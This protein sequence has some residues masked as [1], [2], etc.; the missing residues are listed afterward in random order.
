MWFATSVG[1]F[2]YDSK[3]FKRYV[4]ISGDKKS[5]ASDDLK[6]V[7]C[8][9][10]GD[11]WIGGSAGLDR[12]NRETDSFTHFDHNVPNTNPEHNNQIFSIFEDQEGR[13]L[14]A[15]E[16]GINAVS[17]NGEKV[18]AKIIMYRKFTGGAQSVAFVTQAANGEIW[19]GS[20]NGLMQITNDGEK[21][22]LYHINAKEKSP[23]LNEFS[24]LHIS[25]DS[26]WL[27][28]GAGGLYCFSIKTRQFELI[29]DFKDLNGSLPI[30]T[31][32]TS[33][34]KGNL[35]IS[36]R[37]GL[38]YFDPISRKTRWY[39]NR[40]GNPYSLAEN[41][42]LSMC[43]DKQGG[44]WLGST[45]LGVSNYYPNS[46][47]FLPWP[48]I[49][50]KKTDPVFVNAWMGTDKNK[51]LWIV[52]NG[53]KKMILFDHS[54]S[55]FRTYE[56][57]LSASLDY[58]YFYLDNEDILW[59][60]GNTVLTSYNLKTKVHVNHS[61]NV[62]GRK[63]PL[64]GTTYRILEDSRGRFWIVGTFGAL[65]FNKKTGEF[66]KYASVT[67]SHDL[68]EDLSNNIWIG[69]GD[70][71]FVLKNNKTDF[72]RLL[73]DK[74]RA[75]GNYAAVWRLAQDHSG[76]I[77][78]ATRQG[79]QLF[80]KKL[81]R[82]ELD[83]NVPLEKIEDLRIDR[84]GY[85]WAGT[86]SEL[87]RYHPESRSLQIYGYKDGLPY[88]SISIPASSVEDEAGRFY[89]TTTKGIFRFSPKEIGTV[90][91]QMP[92]VFTSFKLSNKEIQS[93]DNPELLSQDINEVE[94]IVLKHN[95]NIF[96]L[97]F[98]LLSYQRSERNR[99]AYQL[100][101]FDKEWMN[102]NDPTVTYMNL[103]PGNYI[104]QVRASNGDGQWSKQVR[105]LRIKVLAPWWKTWYAYLFYTLLIAAGLYAVTRFFWIRSSF[106]RENALNQIKLD[107]FTNVSHEIRTHLSLISGPLE[108]A[109][110][111]S[112]EGKNNEKFLS[113]A[114]SSSDKLLLLVN[115][116]LDFRKIQSGSVRLQVGEHDVVR[117]L[118]TVIAAFE[119][120]ANEKDI[121]TT[122]VSPERPVMLWFDIAQMQKVFYNLLS[123][124]YKFTPE[125]GKIAVSVT[126]ISNEVIISVADNGKG[127]S[128]DHLR[129]LFTYYYQ[130]DSEKP[131]Y[132]IG[133]ALSKSIVEEHQGYLN[134]ESHLATE[135]SP[136]GT[137]LT[138]RMLRENGHFSQD[139]IAAKNGDS[140]DKV[141]AETMIMPDADRVSQSKQ[142]NTI[143]IIEDNDQL[144]VFIREL[145]EGEFKTLEAEN[146]LRGL[147]LAN[148]HIPDI[149]LSD[150]MMPE[151][152]GLEVCNRLKS[153]VTTSHIPVVLL[154]ARTQNE[155]IIEGLS[156][157]A[158]D[159][160]VKPFD[161]RILELKI[162][163]LIRLRDDMRTRY[164]QSVLMDNDAP[165]SSIARD[166]NEAFIVKLKDLV[167][168]N[169]SDSDFGVNELA[170]EIGM[171]VSV[172][173]RKM[174]SL[175]G[176]TVN[177]F[178]K[179][180]RFNEA[181]KLLE[182]GVYPVGEVASM[183][184]FEDS[185]YFSKEF[186]KTFGK[187][188]NEMKK[189]VTDS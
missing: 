127:I 140:F 97:D 90:D 158:D 3:S 122:F 39:T 184:G 103:P 47:S 173:Y 166:M 48:A 176:M 100:V 149:I 137:K 56:L 138:I 18:T 53:Q 169:L 72:E 171:S 95:Q 85:L 11:L 119:H 23:L 175:T 5:I 161:P 66:K 10:K 153:N 152:N 7:F 61:M 164:R 46:P 145:F 157:G 28:S 150:V 136:G 57:E 63:D 40:P 17:I 38:A 160:L 51:N 55:Q 50:Q 6:E 118:K 36:T 129:K 22:N 4:H 183:I 104:F 1:L 163:N 2:R 32:I 106:R 86:E 139:Q 131:G 188:P 29:S 59:A 43:L 133:L 110:Q 30:V 126:E 177:E 31:K 35:W 165:D 170:S 146:G 130:A 113:Y 187:T 143:L 134:A 121:Q 123:N 125:G 79:L 9:S 71:V 88:N 128:D 182:T 75:S 44:V 67:Y 144:R 186:R 154:T 14:I 181:R 33:D 156:S 34:K 62:P 96:S 8:D 148:E 37:S 172:L 12:Y 69:G 82:F 25:N 189:H 101:G 77:W 147:E 92:I 49:S 74:S 20:F 70:E 115:E 178:V 68:L 84:T 19:A 142:T 135:S 168:E 24:S 102:V 179:S 27:N 42:I 83:S 58:K 151:M 60:A 155:Q 26:I 107:F 21:V 54:Q 174:K 141:L 132:G 108:K 80:N 109:F 117:V 64:H 159:Y 65:L 120:T 41:A 52:E 180:I 15:N 124:A 116:L 105:Q 76:K 78:A 111:Q 98:A 81:N 185:K 114:R 91:H 89:Y 112:A 94:E 93:G 87:V 167:V 73:T 99:Y 162:H 16:F 13:L 45:F